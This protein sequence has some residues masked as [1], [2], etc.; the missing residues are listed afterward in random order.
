MIV[1][2]SVT[3]HVAL[4]ILCN[5]AKLTLLRKACRPRFIVCMPSEIVSSGQLVAYSELDSI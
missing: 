1:V 3:D 5:L 2:G 4:Q